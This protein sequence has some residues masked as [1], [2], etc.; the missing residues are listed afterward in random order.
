MTKTFR[1][2]AGV[3]AV[4]ALLNF[5]VYAADL[6]PALAPD[7]TTLADND[8][9]TVPGSTNS[10][11]LLRFSNAINNTGT[12]PLVVIGYR[13][14]VSRSTI[15]LNNDV[16]PAY[17]RIYRD[18]G[19]YHD[20]LVGELVYHPEH[21]HFHFMGAVRYRL[22]D[23]DTGDVVRE[24]PKVSF[25]LA[26]VEIVDSTLPGFSQVPKFNSC[27]HSP[28]ATSATMGISIGWADVYGKTLMGQAFDVTDLMLLP[29]KEY[30]LEST[31]NAGGALFETNAGDP[32][33]VR[34]PV[35]IGVG[36]PTKIGKSRPGV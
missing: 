7:E 6:L 24:S 34:V 30:L 35:W 22:I 16:M 32:V 21:H 1:G 12:G 2:L 29:A 13:S 18:D 33:A 8:L 10:T 11:V 3:L 17:Q 14:K 36:V 25:C 5:T 19:T 4:L 20:E 31:T 23:P 26:D 28:Y 9:V 27:V 15:D